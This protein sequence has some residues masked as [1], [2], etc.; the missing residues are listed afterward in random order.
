MPPMTQN[1]EAQL[2]LLWREI[3]DLSSAEAVLGWDQETMMPAKGQAARGRALGTLAAV[4]HAKLT[5]SAL[6]DAVA[7][8]EVEAEE[9]SVLEAKARE[10]RRHVDRACKIPSA[11]AKALAE[12]TSAGLV[13]WQSARAADDF[14]LF[15][16]DLAHLVQLNREKAAALSP[17]GPAYDALLDEFEPGATEAELLPLF[18]DLGKELAPLIKAVQ[19]S[20]VVVDESPAQ[21]DFPQQAQED[22]GRKVAKQMGYDF[23]AGRLDLAAHP[24]C[25]GFAIGDVRITWRFLK[26]DFRS[27]LFGIMHEAGHGLYEQ[28]L[29]VD[30][31]G[32][33]I[34]GAVGLGMHESQSRLYENLIG[35]SRAFWHW[36][37][38]HFHAAFPDKATVTVDEM[39]PAL[40]TAKPSLIRVEADEATYNLHIAARFE[41]ERRL[42]SDSISVADLPEFWNQTY[43][44]LLGIQSATAADGVLQDIHW[45]MGAFGYFPTYTLGNLIN[46]QLFE[47]IQEDNPE[48]E[49]QLKTGDL[50]PLRDWLKEKVHRHSS[51][52]S[53][54]KLVENVTAKPL[55][56][57]AFLRYIKTITQEVYGITLNS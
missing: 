46:A 30:W 18:H 17:G 19:D 38:P 13:A 2:D 26:D 8:S 31:E 1:A 24:F 27:A 29:N 9:G 42:F 28:G 45:A 23:E 36:A 40:H 12:S 56:A 48:L 20:G 53:S 15:E 54:A 33:S 44:D 39:F 4:K 43:Q 51:R 37:L 50:Q 55:S 16:K 32:T 47:T 41:V 21:G 14:S 57:S 35:R 49:N 22:F 6:Q 11:L 10:A 25:S 34:G 52:F 7:A 3:A 5:A